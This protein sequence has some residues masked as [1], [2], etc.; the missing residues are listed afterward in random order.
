MLFPDQEE[1]RIIM[2][3]RAAESHTTGEIR[4][5]VEDFCPRDHP[6]ERAAE[7]F[8]LFGMF[9]TKARNAVLLY[10]AEKSRQFALWGDEGIHEKVGFQFWDAEK[11][12][13][14]QYLQRDEACEGI[15]A[16]IDQIGEKLAHHFPASP[17]EA[18]NELP[19][20]IIYG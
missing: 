6:V 1:M 20:E 13:L 16:V 9:N 7:I 10:L 3:I 8:Q 18:D 19:N 15:C 17:G 14:R 5:Y 11:R 4:L 2:A 12:L